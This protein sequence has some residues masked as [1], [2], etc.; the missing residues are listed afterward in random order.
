MAASD[1]AD[2]K[3]YVYDV[4]TRRRL[5]NLEFSTRGFQRPA[6]RD[7]GQTAILCGWSIMSDDKVYAYHWRGND[8]G[9][10]RPGKDF[11]LS[12]ENSRGAGL[13]SDGATIWVSDDRGWRGLRLQFGLNEVR[14]ASEFAGPVRPWRPRQHFGKRGLVGR[15]RDVGVG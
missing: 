2:D 7:C 1:N 15:F 11:N 12:A 3:I 13:W 6:A 4:S 9:D 10:R 8:H 5:S 14:N